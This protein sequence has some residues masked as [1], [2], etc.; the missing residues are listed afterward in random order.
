MKVVWIYSNPSIYIAVVFKK[1]PRKLKRRKSNFILLILQSSMFLT[2][3]LKK[4]NKF[5]VIPRFTLQLVPKKRP[6]KL[7][8]RKSNFILL[9]LQSSMFLT[10]NLIKSYEFTVIPRFTLQL[11]PKKGH[12]NW[13]DVNRISYCS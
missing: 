13:K 11:V 8:R 3:N 1:R 4:L 2:R 9:I 7:K 10:R 12:I 6:R 5:T